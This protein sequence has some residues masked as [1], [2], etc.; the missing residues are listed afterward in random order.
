MNITSSIFTPFPKDYPITAYFDIQH[1]IALKYCNK[2]NVFLLFLFL[3]DLYIIHTTALH[4]LSLSI[5]P[6]PSPWREC[7]SDP[8]FSLHSVKADSP[9][10]VFYLGSSPAVKTADVFLLLPASF[11]SFHS[12][13]GDAQCLV[14]VLGAMDQKCQNNLMVCWPTYWPSLFIKFYHILQLDIPPCTLSHC[15]RAID[16]LLHISGSAV[17][18]LGYCRWQ[19]VCPGRLR[20]AASG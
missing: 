9:S 18:V 12:F 14:Q 11:S 1:F 3:V 17:V 16:L 8:G 4:Q 15:V 13:L 5:L 20:L 10:D 19:S 7:V 2:S 6:I